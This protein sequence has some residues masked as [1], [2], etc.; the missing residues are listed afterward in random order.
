MKLAILSSFNYHMCCIGFVL[1]LFNNYD[2]DVFFPDDRERYLEYYKSLY[3]NMNIN[4]KTIESFSKG[5][6]D[7]CIKI[8]SND[9]VISSEG[10]ISIAHVKE[11]SDNLNKYI[12]MC[13]WIKGE[14]NLFYIFPLYRGIKCKSYDN[15]ITYLG[16]LR[17]DFLDEDTKYFIKNSGLR[18][19]FLGCGMIDEFKNYPN[20]LTTQRL[21]TFEMV[22]SI[23]IS[24][25]ILIRKEPFQCL[26]R[27]SGALGHAVS[28]GKPMI[29]QKYTSDS[30]KLP[31]IIFQKDY[32]EVID[33]IKDM[34]SEEYDNH[35]KELEDFS[36]KTFNEN[37]K[38]LKLLLEK[39][40]SKLDR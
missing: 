13:P 7:L 31:G 33:K 35:V 17:P 4:S 10:I 22:E 39:T 40:I 11:Y 23:K 25:F 8:S 30:Y 26:D 1:E 5:S 28:H 6:Y 14:N 3:S 21:N 18:F 12:V 2:I 29:I 16:Y 9:D 36:E 20:V 24:K 27:Y 34:T 32:S 19:L 37:A 15:I 38:T